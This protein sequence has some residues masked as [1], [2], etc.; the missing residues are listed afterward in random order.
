MGEV[1]LYTRNYL[2]S[3]L[4]GGLLSMGGETSGLIMKKSSSEDDLQV[5][6]LSSSLLLSSLDSSKTFP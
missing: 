1:A 6:N 4:G 2:G 3:P 5:Q